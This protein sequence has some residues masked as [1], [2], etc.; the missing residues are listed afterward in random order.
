M[1]R[2]A[3]LLGLPLAAALAGRAG[4][5][6]GRRIAVIGA[7]MAGLAAARALATAG[8]EVTLYE[9]RS[10]I[11]GR[12]WTDRSWPGLPVDLGASWIHGIRKNPLTALADHLAGV[13]RGHA[14]LQDGLPV[15]LDLFDLD[16]IRVVDQL[17]YQVL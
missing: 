7:G 13:G 14:Q 16:L 5:Q 17:A 15:G 9:A 8:A 2:R 3:V 12:L 6:T 4:A 1:N 10:R 11:G